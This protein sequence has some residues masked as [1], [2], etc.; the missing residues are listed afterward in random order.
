MSESAGDSKRKLAGIDLGTTYSAIAHFDDHGK[1]AVIPN[2][3]NERITPSVILFEDDEIIVGKIAKNQAVSNPGNVIQF[4]KRQVGDPDWKKTINGREYTPEVLSAIIL[5][6]ILTDAEDAIDDVITDVVITCP[7]Y[8]ND[9][10]RKATMDAGRIAGVNVLG[11][12]NEPTAAVLSYGLQNLDK[13][14]RAL[15]YDL[16][17]G[18]FDVTVVEINGNNVKVLATDGERRLGGKDWDD[19][20][21]NFVSES[22]LD[23]HD[24]DPRDDPEAYQDLVNKCEEAK[25]A[26]SRK[27]RTKVFAQCAGKSLKVE[28]TKE[29][30]EEL[31]AP[32]L[33]QTETYLEVVLQKAGLSWAEIDALL[34][35]GGSTRMP[36][37]P[38]ML[39]R[40]AGREPEKGVN[41]DE[42][43]AMGAVYWGAILLM[44][45][46]T[47]LQEKV[48]SGEASEAELE[49]VKEAQGRLEESVPEE[50]VGL[51]E[52][53]V[54]SNVNSHPLGI[55]VKTRDGT[56]KN[57]VMIPDQTPLPCEITKI[58]GTFK[59][60]QQSVEIKIV[61]GASADP[62][63]CTRI[64][65]AV[66]TDLPP[67]RPKGSLVSVTYKYDEDGRIHLVARD[68]ES[69]QEVRT[70]I[71]RDDEMSEDDYA[72]REREVDQ[73][74]REGVYTEDVSP[75]SE[76][77]AT[78][79]Y[80]DAGTGE[81]AEA[82]YE[83][84]EYADTGYAEGG[85]E[86][87]EYA[88][89]G[90]QTGDY[91][92]GQ[93]ADGQYA[94]GQYAD[95]QYVEGQYV[96]GQYA[97]GQYVEGQ[98]A[99][100]QYADGQYADGQYAD[101]QYV[102]GQYADGQYADGQYVEGQYADG[103]YVEGQYPE[104]QYADGQYAEGQYPEGQ[105]ADGQYVEGQYPEGQYAD[106]QYAE[107]QYADGQYAEYAD[108]QY[109]EGQY[110]EYAEGQYPEG[111]YA[112]YAEGQYPEGQY[113][114]GQYPEGQYA[115][116]ADGQVPEGQYPDGQFA[117]GAWAEG[118]EGQYQDGQYG[119]GYAE[120]EEYR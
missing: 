21:I 85:Y 17:G 106:G 117:D 109:P 22:F 79:E 101:G 54:V 18:T 7:A 71:K 26:L 112:E 13:K 78:G 57:I 99:D 110:A 60:N 61:E 45:E 36:Q 3:D 48:E 100:G 49:A 103:Q 55:V 1:A 32:L 95:G 20:V 115:E 116:Y 69:G 92:E 12:I 89:T 31:T 97:D 44:R 16:G 59:D 87:G 107:G 23:E 70:E 94:D 88:D 82:S 30:F 68:Q 98:Y 108:G 25:K 56:A 40:V 72:Q 29:Q 24:V 81:Y 51:L 58:F 114:E 75:V 64:G 111:Q 119:E 52:G 62:D 50:I 90:F 27:P 28:I 14:Q 102:E 86:T 9:T 46:Q 65:T 76:M 10:E 80:A 96:E 4:V 77:V 66:I 63:D 34:M 2:S 118:A 41:P 37:V 39:Q 113:P 6:R 42:C 15:V 11:L 47:Q 105:Y 53:V 67:N 35:V 104:G 93:Y 5:K 91:T 84:G 19:M 73:L 33:E 38:E 120:G 8:F 83:T 74:V 43:V